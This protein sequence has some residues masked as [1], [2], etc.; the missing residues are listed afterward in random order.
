MHNLTFGADDWKNNTI[1]QIRFDLSPDI[2][3]V[4]E[5]DW[6]VVG[7]RTSEVLVQVQPDTKVVDRSGEILDV[8]DI[9]AGVPLMADGVLDV[10][11]DPHT[12]NAALIVIDSDAARTSKLSGALGVIPDGAC[13]LSFATSSGDRSVSYSSSTRAYLVSGA[14]SRQ[15][16]VG[17]LPAGFSA[18]VH[19]V[20][21][22]DGCFAANRIFAFE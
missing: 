6:V 9:E 1:K 2:G 21:G 10:N 4:F 16:A 8:D 5:I 14:G 13:G 20:E 12:L 3:P 19:G 15:I 7:R 17:A 11:V 18:D 22:I